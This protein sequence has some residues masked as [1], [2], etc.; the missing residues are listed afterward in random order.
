M[1]VDRECCNIHTIT[2]VKATPPLPP[3]PNS[4]QSPAGPVLA[5]DLARSSRNMFGHHGL[6]RDYGIMFYG[7]ATACFPKH[8]LKKT[9]KARDYDSHRH[10][11][12]TRRSKQ[13]CFR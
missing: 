12:V 2:E 7:R 6:W 3:L 13:G 10:R 4:E 8:G 9:E 11:Q 1:K 5:D